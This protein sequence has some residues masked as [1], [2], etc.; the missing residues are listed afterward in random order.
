MTGVPAGI[1]LHPVQLYGVLANL[2][3][4][5]L[6]YLVLRRKGWGG[7]VA[8]LYFLLYPLIRFLLEFLRDD[9]RGGLLGLSTSQGIALLFAAGAA[10]LWPVVRGL[11]IPPSCP[12][13]R[14]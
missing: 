8:L 9:P 13:P 6:L 14:R 7:Q 3:L 5:G 4:S 10:A 11:K 1:P 12:R 2:L